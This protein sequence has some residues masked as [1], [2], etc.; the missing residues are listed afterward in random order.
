MKHREKYPGICGDTSGTLTYEQLEFKVWRFRKSIQ[1]IVIE[2]FFFS[3]FE[4][5]ANHRSRGCEEWSR[6]RRRRRR[7]T[8]R[9]KKKNNN[10]NNNNNKIPPHHYGQISEQLLKT[11][12]FEMS[13]IKRHNSHT[14]TKIITI[15]ISSETE[16]PEGK[17]VM[18][19]SEF[20]LCPSNNE[21]DKYP[22][23]YGFNPWPCSVG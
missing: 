13:R 10:N 5:I 14:S 2:E 1:K 16:K 8:K 22:W 18:S 11:E 19:E 20:P 17:R 15:D 6:I 4:N 21:P 9:K 23:V 7:R 12:K 3:M